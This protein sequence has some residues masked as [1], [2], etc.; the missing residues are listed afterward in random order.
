MTAPHN[1]PA[2]QE[3]AW[4]GRQPEPRKNWSGK[5]TAAV[6]AIA[7]GLAAAG[8]FAV[9]AATGSAGAATSQPGMGG[10]GGP[11]GGGMRGG[12]V[13]DALH[14]EFTISDGN[15]GYKT[16]VMQT[17]EVTAISDTSLTTKSADGYTKIYTI[18][19]DTL[20]GNGSSSD[21]QSGDTI[22]VG[23]TPEGDSATADSVSER[24]QGQQGGPGGQGAPPGQGN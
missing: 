3:L 2:D 17:G 13:M 6:V 19:A 10:M 21:I 11:G 24:G 15:G 4:G 7:V 9:Y 12:G 1:D 5:K 22:T 14:G 16:A 23:A 18:D 20:F 8:G